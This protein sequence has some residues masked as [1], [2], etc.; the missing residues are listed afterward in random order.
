VPLLLGTG[1]GG[2]GWWRIRQSALQTAP[3]TP[4]L[5]QAYRHQT[6]LAALHEQQLLQALTSLRSAGVEPLLAKGWVVA[7][8]YP[9]PGLRPYG[10][11]DLFVTPGQHST[12]ASAVRNLLD[13]GCP[14]DLHVGLSP[15]DD[16]DA[17]ETYRR[18]DR[19]SF[20][21]I[22]VR[23][24]GPEDQLRFLCQHLLEHGA[25][26]P[27]WLCDVAAALESRPAGF[28]W[29][30]FLRRSRQRSRGI[31]CALALAHHLL[32]ARLDDTPLAGKTD[33]LPGW[34]VAAVLGRWGIGCRHRE[35]LIHHLR[36]RDGVLESLRRSWPDPITA[37][38]EVHGPF[39][40]LPRLPFQ[41][42]FCLKRSAQI[43]AELLALI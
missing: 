40:G 3:A 33:A 9:E 25:W 15:L 24:L 37:T 16:R 11:I 29:D 1:G 28:D 5:V 36:R 32:E 17:G 12:A 34:L 43:A 6:L 31:M 7:R 27:L 26:R 38:A 10:D 19:V 30:Y 22:E 13:Q 14:V 42:A 4:R 41:I 18:V 39:N 20:G 2:L 8:L 21:G 35:P 23:V